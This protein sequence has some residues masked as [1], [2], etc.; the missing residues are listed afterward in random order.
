MEAAVLIVL[1]VKMVLILFST[2]TVAKIVETS[3][4]LGSRGLFATVIV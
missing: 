4:I 3:G 1:P 2:Q